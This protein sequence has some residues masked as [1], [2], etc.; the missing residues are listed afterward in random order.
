LIEHCGR[1]S[2]LIFRLNAFL[3][4]FLLKSEEGEIVVGMI[5]RISPFFYFYFFLF[6]FFNSIDTMH[7]EFKKKLKAFM[8]ESRELEKK[9]HTKV[10]ATEIPFRFDVKMGE[11]SFVFKYVFSQNPS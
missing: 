4:Q 2:V 10:V 7:P 3:E 1:F 5:I 8:K 6:I 9:V 11:K